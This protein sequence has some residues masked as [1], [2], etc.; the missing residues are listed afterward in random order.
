MEASSPSRAGRYWCLGLLAAA[1]LTM[2]FVRVRL[3]DFPLERDEGEYAYAGQLILE[4]VPPYR[5]CYNMKWPAP[6]WPTPARW[7][8][9]ARL[10]RESTSGVLCVTTGSALLV[11]LIG[12][13]IGGEGMGAVAGSAQALLGMN[14]SMLG[15]AGHATISLRSR[16]LP[17]SGR[18]RRLGKKS[19]FGAGSRRAFFSVSLA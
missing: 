7:R 12:R 3:L 11:F 17:T 14:P 15:L 18:L 9:L 16:R 19:G 5:E 8:S 10:R 1:L 4:G 2:G 13:R 6:I